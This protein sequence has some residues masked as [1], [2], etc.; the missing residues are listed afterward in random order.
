[1]TTKQF[2]RISRKLF[3][4]VLEVH[5]FTAKQSGHSTFYRGVNDDIYHIVAPDQFRS[6]SYYSVKIFACSRRLDPLFDKR[7]PDFV[8]VPSDVFCH[9]S[10]SGVGIDKEVFGCKTPETFAKGFSTRVKPMLLEVIPSYFNDQGSLEG[11][12]K[13]IRTPLYLAI[14]LGLIK[15]PSSNQLLHEQL[16]RLEALNDSDEVVVSHIERIKEIL[17]NLS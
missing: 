16:H 5:G 9:L 4:E 15:D 2:D 10:K 14:A 17:A 6:G 11:M 1:M 3:G 8:G 12:L 7:F 13:Y